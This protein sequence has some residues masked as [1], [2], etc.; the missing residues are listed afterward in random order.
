MLTIPLRD[1]D[2]MAK[3]CNILFNLLE[4]IGR[5]GH[6]F[7][8]TLRK[9]YQSQI[10][11]KL[12]SNFRFLD[13]CTWGRGLKNLIRSLKMIGSLK[14]VFN[15][16]F[17]WNLFW[18]FETRLKFIKFGHWPAISF[19]IINSNLSFGHRII[20]M[21]SFKTFKISYQNLLQRNENN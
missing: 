14:I 1:R 18:G 9:S 15:F 8:F 10:F 21:K 5:M 12:K 11:K 13:Y 17:N 16:A 4:N 2:K 6:M 3:N 20:K 7:T 19:N